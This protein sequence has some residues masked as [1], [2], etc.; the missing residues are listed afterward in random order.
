LKKKEEKIKKGKCFT[1][2]SKMDEKYLKPLFIYKYEHD[3][4]VRKEEFMEL[5]EKEGD[6]WEKEYVRDTTIQKDDDN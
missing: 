2:L 5:F 4:A 6:K 1:F 3:E